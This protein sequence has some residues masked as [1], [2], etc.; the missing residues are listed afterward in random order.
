MWRFVGDVS[1][2]YNPPAEEFLQLKDNMKYKLGEGAKSNLFKDMLEPS[3]DNDQK[4]LNGGDKE[5]LQDP[6]DNKENVNHENQSQNQSDKNQTND[7]LKDFKET[8]LD[9]DQQEDQTDK[10][11]DLNEENE[12]E[13]EDE[14]DSNIDANSEKKYYYNGDSAHDNIIWLRN[15]KLTLFT[16]GNDIIVENSNTGIQTVLENGHL[17]E[18]TALAI[19]QDESLL[20]S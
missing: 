4:D 5:D 14:P 20:A 1:T 11:P 7:D 13:H 8:P 19:S 10:R 6:T 15:R 16:S 17:T 3:Q 12:F 18:I 2:N 9:Q